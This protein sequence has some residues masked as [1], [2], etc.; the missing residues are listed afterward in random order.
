[1]EDVGDGSGV[2]EVIVELD[3][4]SAQMNGEDDV[5]MENLK[6][7]HILHSLFLKQFVEGFF[8]PSSTF[9][10]NLMFCLLCTGTYL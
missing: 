9:I 1:M 2:P 10:N 8:N 3:Q 6:V 5:C 4:Y 7:N